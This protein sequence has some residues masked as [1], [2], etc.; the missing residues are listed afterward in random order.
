MKKRLAI[1]LFC[2]A[3][4]LA[5]PP[6]DAA[7]R[8]VETYRAGGDLKELAAQYNSCPWLVADELCA[9]GEYDAAEAFAKAAPRP[10]TEKL[11]AYVAA[12]S[13]RNRRPA[14]CVR[15]SRARSR[16]CWAPFIYIGDPR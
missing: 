12:H 6:E 13:E 5:G 16:F 15:R 1:V 3:H 8:V 2:A 14:R 4:A 11:P 10:D 9:R 7:D